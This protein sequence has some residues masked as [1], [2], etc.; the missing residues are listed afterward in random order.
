MLT[1]QPKFS[2]YNSLTP[3]FSG[4]S[5]WR[6]PKTAE[7]L[8]AEIREKE[9][10]EQ[11]KIEEKYNDSVNS[12]EKAKDAALE[13]AEKAPKPIKVAGK[14]LAATATALLGGMAL[15]WGGHKSI[16]AVK[17]LLRTDVGVKVAAKIKNGYHALA[18]GLK[19]A[20][21]SIQSGYGSLKTKFQQSN[22]YA[23]AK[24]KYN[25]FF[26]NTKAGQKLSS[27]KNKIKQNSVYQKV[28]EAFSN[29]YRWCKDGVT[30]LYRKVRGIKGEQVEKATV[31][32]LGV[33]GG[34][35]SGVYA[36]QG[37]KMNEND[38]IDL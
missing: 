27:A 30:S 19:N 32:T 13:L 3:A 23:N 12:V 21:D 1:I 15:G 2:N 28:T 34:I 24:T 18:E 4:R 31:N 36:L 5:D 16:Q 14:T 22:F 20:K 10:E 17:E 11:R 7:E 33:S 8:E 37:E 6:K 35:S 9:L 29:A 26:D 38:I 25:N